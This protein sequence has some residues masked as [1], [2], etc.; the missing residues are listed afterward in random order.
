MPTCLNKNKKKNPTHTL[1]QAFK[2]IVSVFLSFIHYENDLEKNFHK[3][4]QVINKKQERV[5]QDINVSINF[6]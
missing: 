5:G 6:T 1:V 4:I 2:F 3:M